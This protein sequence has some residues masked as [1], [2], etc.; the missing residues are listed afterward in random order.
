MKELTTKRA[1]EIRE[2]AS[3]NIKEILA[4]LPEGKYKKVLTG[5][6]FDALKF[7]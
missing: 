7:F 3:L 5:H 2:L 6:V 1:D 4:T